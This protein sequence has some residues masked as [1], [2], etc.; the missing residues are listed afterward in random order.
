WMVMQWRVYFHVSDHEAHKV[1]MR[2]LPHRQCLNVLP[3]PQYGHP[4]AN[5]F[6]LLK[7]MRYVEDCHALGFE[8]TDDPEQFG[9]FAQAQGR[10]WL[11]HDHNP[12]L[13][14]KRL[15]RLHGLPLAYAEVA[16]R[17]LRI[18]RDAEALQDGAG[19]LILAREIDAAQDPVLKP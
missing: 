9:D 3:I 2:H 7:A 8:L 14:R 10:C 18:N 1:S 16:N 17:R 12:R 5:L 13:L 15:R 6:G 19:L 11:V 4:V